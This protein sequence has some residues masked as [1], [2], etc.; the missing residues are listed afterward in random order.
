MLLLHEKVIVVTG[1]GHGIGRAHALYLAAL[2]AKVVVNNR[3]A[4]DSGRARAVDEV[5][6]L[7]T[8][9]GGEAVA[10]HGDV[11]SFG[12]AEALIQQALDVFGRLDGL[13]LN[14][15]ILR[16]RMIF[17]MDESDWDDVVRIHLKG[18]FAPAR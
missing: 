14:A 17:R 10:N 3:G 6:D 8:R 1:A 5:V 16:D 7:I 4:S 13:V 9:S 15:G 11:A 18:H 12:D 2:G